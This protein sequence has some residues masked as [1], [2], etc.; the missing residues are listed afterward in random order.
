MRSSVSA[1]LTAGAD[2]AATVSSMSSGCN[3]VPLQHG[4]FQHDALLLA[5]LAL[6]ALAAAALG[7][8]GKLRSSSRDS[9]L[10]LRAMRVRAPRSTSS[11]SG[12]CATRRGE[13]RGRQPA[14]L[15]AGG[16]HEP[17]RVA[18]VRAAGAS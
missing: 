2:S 18:R 10:G 9:A 8:C 12:V 4:R 13:Q 15:L 1:S 3:A 16:V 14:V 7:P 17:P 11:A 6:A 5:A